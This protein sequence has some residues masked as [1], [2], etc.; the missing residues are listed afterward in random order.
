MKAIVIPKFGGPDVLQVGD[1]SAPEPSEQE[2]MVRV[3]AA[4]INFADIMTASGGYPG[5]PPPPL[6]AGREYCG[7]VEDPRQGSAD[8]QGQRVMGY[9]QWGAFAELVAARRNYFWPSDS[10]I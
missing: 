5:G 6:V 7:V 2:V 4:G 3:Q 1:V 9:T 8:I 10:S